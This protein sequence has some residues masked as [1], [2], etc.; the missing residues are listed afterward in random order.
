MKT[1]KVCNICKPFTDFFKNGKRK[2]HRSEEVKYQST[3]KLCYKVA[4]A[5]HYVKNKDYYKSKSLKKYGITNAE[6]LELKAAQ[7]GLCACC[8]QPETRINYRNPE[9]PISE[10]A[11]D[12]CHTTD[13]IR[14]LLCCKCNFAVGLVKD[15][16]E[17]LKNLIEYLNAK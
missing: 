16:I 1:C 7:N 14:G 15:N 5:E 10:L 17:T 6:F 4:R 11:V 3:C 2:K 9:H 8:K 13:K 12:H